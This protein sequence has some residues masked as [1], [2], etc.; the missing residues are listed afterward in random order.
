MKLAST[1]SSDLVRSYLREIGRIPLL[2]HEEEIILGKQVQALSKLQVIRDELQEE[3]GAD[4]SLEA[5]AERAN[6]STSELELCI[7]ILKRNMEAGG[8]HCS[9][10]VPKDSCKLTR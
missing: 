6:I 9:P 3:T 5:W 10:S 1:S 4:V 7:S 2:T 8:S